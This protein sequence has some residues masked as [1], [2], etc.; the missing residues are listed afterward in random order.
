[1][2]CGRLSRKWMRK[3]SFNT[4]TKITFTRCSPED[5]KGLR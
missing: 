4:G 1:M 5:A 2:I 3:A